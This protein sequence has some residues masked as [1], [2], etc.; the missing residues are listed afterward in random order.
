MFFHFVN[1]PIAKKMNFVGI[2]KIRCVFDEFYR[3]FT[4]RDKKTYEKWQLF[5]AAEMW[6]NENIHYT[7]SGGD[8]MQKFSTAEGYRSGIKS[9]LIP[10]TEIA[11]AVRK[12]GE[13]I[14]SLYD[15]KPI[16]LI[17]ILNG[18]FV[19]MADVCRA[20]T[21]PCEIAFMKVKSYDG[22]EST[23]EV[24]IHMDVT[25]DLSQYN[26]VIIEDIID[27]GRTLYEVTKLLKKRNPRSFRV[28]TLLDKPSRRDPQVQAAG[29]R[30]DLVLFSIPDHFVIGY[31]LDCN[32]YY[33]TLPYIAIF[34]ETLLKEE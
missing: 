3:H 23:G 20:V 21:V 1:D 15:G 24:Q 8:N 25:Q 22:T 29:F 18:A 16:L 12:A 28:V 2:S 31:G 13:E 33:R 19:F 30:A 27:T 17:S 4:N 14:D 34:D 5:L 11:E 6:Y 32:E 9:I 10:E 26:V 7:Q